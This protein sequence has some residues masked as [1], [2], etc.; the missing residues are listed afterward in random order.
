MLIEPRLVLLD[1]HIWL[2]YETGVSK[3]ISPKLRTLIEKLVPDS[4][5]R[6]S[7]IS[8]W[9]IGNL[10][11]KNKIAFPM[12]V[13]EWVYRAVC[14]PGIRL[15]A[16]DAEIAIESTLLSEGFHGDPADRI[17]LA[18]ARKIGATLITHDKE[19]LAYSKKHGLPAMSL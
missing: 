18:T 19:I 8:V 2:W 6:V 5:V 11:L 1:T 10:V 3:A 14:Q 13:K 12:G 4:G 15:E 17:L 16:I 9:E 7:A